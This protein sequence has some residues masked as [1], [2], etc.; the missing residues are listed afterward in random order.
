MADRPA[1]M[2]KTEKMEKTGKRTRRVSRWG[3]PELGGYQRSWLDAPVYY[4]GTFTRGP[5]RVIRGPGSRLDAA[6]I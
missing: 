1:K 4:V 6:T 2:G 3:P 5:L